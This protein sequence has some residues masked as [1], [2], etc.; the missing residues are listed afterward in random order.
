M[1]YQPASGR[2]PI[3]NAD[4][5]LASATRIPVKHNQAMSYISSLWALLYLATSVANR[6]VISLSEVLGLCFRSSLLPNFRTFFIT[7]ISLEYINIFFLANSKTCRNVA[8]SLFTVF[9]FGFLAS[10]LIYNPLILPA[11]NITNLPSVN[12]VPYVL[13]GNAV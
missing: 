13:V 9:Q 8:S 4:K 12:E 10:L 1:G 11:G 5:A 7:G 6:C 3:G 2:S